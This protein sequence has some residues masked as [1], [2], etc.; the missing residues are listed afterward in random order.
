MQTFVKRDEIDSDMFHVY[1]I[2]EKAWKS[3]IPVLKTLLFT[4]HED[5]L[6]GLGE[7]FRRTILTLDSGEEIDVRLTAEILC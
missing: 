2:E 3:T 1:G 4:I 7:T 5:S 6:R